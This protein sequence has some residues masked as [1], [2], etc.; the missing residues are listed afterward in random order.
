MRLMTKNIFVST[1]I[2]CWLAF[3]I[4]AFA[5]DGA[6]SAAAAKASVAALVASVQ[7][8]AKNSERP[9]YK[10]EPAAGHLKRI[11]DLDA[12]AA[13]P[14]EKAS[15]I[16]WLLDWGDAANTSYKILVTYDETGKDGG[17]QAA[18]HN[19]MDHEG[20]IANGLAF[21]LRLQSRMA[22]T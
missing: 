2:A 19:F 8:A 18:V 16:E 5:G 17:V 6:Q 15:D 21:T 4:P 22:R 12:L 9:D 14:P 3:G 13:L 10:K 1:T 7:T 20:E 11:F